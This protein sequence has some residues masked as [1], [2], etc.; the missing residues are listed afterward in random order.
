MEKK[1]N[2]KTYVEKLYQRTAKAFLKNNNQRGKRLLKLQELR[3]T[4]LEEKQVN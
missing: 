2:I 3:E 4:L 1:K